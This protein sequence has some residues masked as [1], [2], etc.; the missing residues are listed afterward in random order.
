MSKL[1]I[2]AAREVIKVAEKLGLEFDRQKGSHAVYVRVSDKRRIVIPVHKGRDLK[3]GT[4]RGLIDDMGLS[5][6]RSLSLWSETRLGP[7]ARQG[8]CLCVGARRQVG[9]PRLPAA[10]LAAQAGPGR[11]VRSDEGRPLHLTRPSLLRP[12]L[13][14]P[15][16]SG[17]TWS[18]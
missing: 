8:I 14:H 9:I 16:C 7:G 15:D 10:T 1:P 17:R 11:A 18:V 12:W 6:W 2:V 13:R 3:P 4:R 5:V